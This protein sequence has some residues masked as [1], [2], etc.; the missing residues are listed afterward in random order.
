M[1]TGTDLWNQGVALLNNQDWRGFVSLFTSDA[2]YAG[3]T[4][5]YDGR[6]AIGAHFDQAGKAISDI[7][8]ET[9]LVV[10]DGDSVMAEWT[11]RSTQT[12]QLPT[13]L[14]A[15]ASEGTETAPTGG[16]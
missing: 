13:P 16:A 10:E 2:L 3:P 8:Y 12:G 14:L 15:H 11:W 5:C 9:S 6:E 7:H 1:G 4:T